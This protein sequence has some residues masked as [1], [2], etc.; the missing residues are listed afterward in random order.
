MMFGWRN[1]DVAAHLGSMSRYARA[2]TRHAED[3]EDL[4]H[5]ALVRAY[6]RR[7]TFRRGENLRTWLFAILHNSFVDGWRRRAAEEARIAA[8]G[9]FAPSSS[10]PDQHQA[11]QLRE[12]FDAYLALPEPQRAAFHLVALE[13]LSY[14]EAAEV[15]GVPPGT[16]MS[17]LNRA[18]TALRQLG[19]G[20]AAP[21]RAPHLR[22]VEGSN[23]PQ[24]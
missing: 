21:P 24:G 23:D 2:L 10:G 15:L 6:E 18:R 17:R 12:L 8:V 3:A 1:F 19:E 20:G 16:V 13:G 5:T 9:S 7:S 11:V 4:V 22:L 14:Q